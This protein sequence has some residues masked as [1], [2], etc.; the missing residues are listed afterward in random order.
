MP[1]TLPKR[2]NASKDPCYK[3][4]AWLTQKLIG[5]QP[6]DAQVVAWGIGTAV[7][8]WWIGKTLK[9][10]DAPR[11]LQNFWSYTTIAHSSYAVINNHQNGVR[12]FNDNQSV[13]GCRA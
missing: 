11:W 2:L 1:L 13:D 8:H 5:E 6:S 9:E 4:A 3:E 10:H 7:A 12:A